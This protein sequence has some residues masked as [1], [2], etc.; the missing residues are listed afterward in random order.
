MTKANKID[1]KDILLFKAASSLNLR[2][3]Q[4]KNFLNFLN[5]NKVK[6]PIRFAF[7]EKDAPLINN[8]SL[9]ENIYLDSVPNT[10][11]S[12]KD[13]QLNQYLEKSGN[14]YLLEIYK[15][16]LLLDETPDKV[17]IVTRKL[18]ALLK[19]LIQDCDYLFLD[20]PEEYLNEENLEIFTQALAI[21]TGLTGKIVFIHSDKES[22]WV[23]H[24]SKTVV[25]DENFEFL[26]EPTFNKALKAKFA[27]LENDQV[28]DNEGHLEISG[29]KKAA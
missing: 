28:D 11:I 20:H 15:R 1:K 21:Q 10:L 29:I 12:S 14:K 27:V 18:A 13:F 25:R 5:T 8:L 2:H 9:R 22:L 19:G 3:C 16:L 26:V 23:E 6:K 7:I 24:V 17:D 4:L